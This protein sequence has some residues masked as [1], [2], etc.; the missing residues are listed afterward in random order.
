MPVAGRKPKP[1]GQKRNRVKSAIDW[2][3][4]L[5]IAFAGGPKLPRR[6]QGWPARTKQWWAAVSTMPHCVLWSATDWQFA[7][8]TANVHALF[9]AGD[10][11]VAPELR[12]REKILGTTM[13]ARRDLRI[14]Y[15][16]SSS[17]SS[18]EGADVTSL[19]DYRDA[20]A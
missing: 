19:D 14:R 13:D 5:D 2:V 7:I 17:E 8:D 9:A 11:R 18:G 1:D 20:L 15:V 10:A 6:E 12:Q 4:V 16:T 3:E